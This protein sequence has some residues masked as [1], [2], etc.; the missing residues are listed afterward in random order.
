MCES[1]CVHINTEDFYQ[2]PDTGNKEENVCVYMC[3]CE[4]ESE[5]MIRQRG[6]REQIHMHITFHRKTIYILSPY[7][8]NFEWPLQIILLHR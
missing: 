6:A 7:Y 3:V 8:V 2:F 4:G 1:L 5:G